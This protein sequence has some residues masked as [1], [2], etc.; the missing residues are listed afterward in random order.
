M[1]RSFDFTARCHRQADKSATQGD[2]GKA[3]EA[4]LK[5]DAK[6]NS[7]AISSDIVA[8]LPSRS[9][10]EASEEFRRQLFT[11]ASS[12]F[13]LDLATEAAQC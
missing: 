5:I 12:D 4:L 8:S 6:V 10:S 1:D 13:A 7:R 2:F 3:M 9:L 11:Y